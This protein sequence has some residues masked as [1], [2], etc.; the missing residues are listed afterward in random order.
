MA[1]KGTKE[2]GKV[3]LKTLIFISALAFFAWQIK[4]VVIKYFDRNTTMA[5]LKRPSRKLKPPAITFHT[6]STLKKSFAENFGFSS[7]YHIENVEHF[8]NVSYILGV[9]FELTIRNKMNTYDTYN[10]TKGQYTI[11]NGVKVQVYETYTFYSGIVYTVQIEKSMDLKND[12]YIF[13]IIFRDTVFDE[14]VPREFQWYL[15]DESKR[16]GF[17]FNMWSGTKPFSF[18]TEIGQYAMVYYEQSDWFMEK[19]GR[20]TCI[21]Y[22]EPDESLLKCKARVA[23]ETLR[24]KCNTTCFAPLSKTLLTIDDKPGNASQ[25]CA[26]KKDRDCMSEPPWQLGSDDAH[27]HEP[28]KWHEY[29]GTIIAQKIFEKRSTMLAFGLA[30]DEVDEYR[31]YVLFDFPNFI[32]AFGGSLGLFI[33]FSYFDFASMTVDYLWN[34]LST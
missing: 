2:K 25:E 31:E 20:R 34:R 33:G 32:G 4:D 27:C 16:H 18:R 15:T 12:L 23:A 17:I 28:C 21:E 30:S 9:D 26:N 22:D 5:L 1:R 8:R 11:E 3:V 24:K 10:L 29:Q 13:K 7:Y 19:T 14:D 6:L